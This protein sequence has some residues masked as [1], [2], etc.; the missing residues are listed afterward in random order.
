MKKATIYFKETLHKALKI[1]SIESSMSVSDI[2]ND[3]VI[4]SFSEDLEDL[5]AFEDRKNETPISYE[6]FLKQLKVSGRI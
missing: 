6:K 2:V 5:Q 3:A 4:A 1:K